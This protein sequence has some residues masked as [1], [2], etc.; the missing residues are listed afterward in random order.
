[1]KYITLTLITLFALTSC[2]EYKNNSDEIVNE[3]KQNSIDQTSNEKQNKK[4]E[5]NGNQKLA[6]TY[7][8]WT[9][10]L[11]D[12][13]NDVTKTNMNY[14]GLAKYDSNTNRYE[15]F[16]ANTWESR[17]DKWVYFVT[18][19]NKKRIN[20]SETF[21]YSAIIELID[22]DE[23]IFT[24]KR[25]GKNDSWDDI[26]VNVEHIPYNWEFDLKFSD[27]IKLNWKSEKI[28]NSKSWRDILS[29]TNWKGTVALDEM[30]NDVSEYNSNFL[31]LAKYDSNTNRYEFF[32][33]NTWVS[34]W[35]KGYFDVIRNNTVRVHVSET[36]NYHAILEL[37]ELNSNKF[38]YKRMWK[39]KDWEDILITVEHVPYNW[40][41]DLKFTD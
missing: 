5:M 7:W 21:N 22:L 4:K 27:E 40:E 23:N 41:F 30:W 12:N 25:M 37:T 2:W 28:D 11:D 31:W 26:S 38:T 24:Y 20:I 8:K 18:N 14:I 13:W 33:A 39:N 1:M 36:F 10:A 16:D 3:T 32:D 6:N 19:D 15:F 17:W 34:R 35:D 29:S 9:V